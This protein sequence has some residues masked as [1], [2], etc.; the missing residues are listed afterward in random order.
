MKVCARLLTDVHVRARQMLCDG[1][2]LPF[3][4]PRQTAKLFGFSAALA[5]RCRYPHTSLSD[6][7]SDAKQSE[8]ERGMSGRGSAAIDAGGAHSAAGGMF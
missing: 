1:A 6:V 2:T 8:S 5:R 4:G 3:G 7:G